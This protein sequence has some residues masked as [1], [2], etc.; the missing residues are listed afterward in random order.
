[1]SLCHLIIKYK[2]LSYL[3]NH[4]SSLWYSNTKLFLMNRLIIYLRSQLHILIWISAIYSLMLFAKKSITLRGDT[5]A[6]GRGV[7][8]FF[9]KMKK[10]F[11]WKMKKKI[12]FSF[13]FLIRRSDVILENR[14][15][16]WGEY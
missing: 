7:I 3:K 8:F 12:F 1:M 16:F 5:G 2:L 13:L 9:L 4:S 14:S 15:K 10:K 11:F 6:K